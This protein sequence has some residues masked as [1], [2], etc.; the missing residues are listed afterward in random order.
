[1]DKQ[2]KKSKRKNNQGGGGGGSWGQ[3]RLGGFSAVFPKPSLPRLLGT[4]NMQAGNAVYPRVYL[5]LP[6]VAQ[7]VA[8]SSGAVAAV[9]NVAQAIISNFS[10]FADCFAQFTILGARFE[11]RVTVVASGQGLV[12]LAMSDES[13]GAALGA[14]V[15][16]LPHIEV[17]IPPTLTNQPAVQRIDWIC[18]EPNDLQFYSTG[19]SEAST[20]IQ[21][22][23]ATATTGTGASTSATLY[24]TGTVRV[25]FQG[26]S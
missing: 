13:V 16:N 6:I 24:I 12:F 15:A 9:I 5:D 23:A 22:Y 18:R 17:P 21:A 20:S 10:S 1:M 8:I 25:C 11:V 2:K 4:N 14:P 3:I 26:F 7:S 19:S